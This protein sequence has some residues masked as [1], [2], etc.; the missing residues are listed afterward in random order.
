MTTDHEGFLWLERERARRA[1]LPP[2]PPIKH[3]V[4]YRVGATLDFYAAQ[5]LVE[6]NSYRWRAQDTEAL[7]TFDEARARLP[8]PFW[9]GHED[10]IR[11]YWWTWEK[12]FAN[13]R[14]PPARAFITNYIDTAFNGG[15]FLWDSIF[16][17]CFGRYGERV[18]PF[19]RTLDNFYALQYPDGFLPR[20]LRPDGTNQF[21][22]HDPAS[23]GPN[24][25]AWSEWGHYEMTGDRERLA[26]V[27]PV[28]LAYHRWL[29]LNRSWPDGSYFAC[30]LSGGADN[31]DRLPP[32]YEPHVHHGHLA[33]IDSSAQA[34]LS[35][36]LLLRMGEVLGRPDELADER[37]ELDLLRRWFNDRAWDDRLGMPTDVRRDG[38]PTGVKQVGCY[39]ALLAGLPSE[40][41][42]RRMA[43]HLEDP[44]SFAR[45]HRVP[46]L[47]A[48]Q[49]GYSEEGRYWNGSIWAPTNWM[50]LKA[51]ERYGFDDIAHNI[52][53]NHHDNVVRIW[54]ETGTVWENYAPDSLRPGKPAK[55]DF[56]GWTGLPP[57]AVL[58]EHRFGLRPKVP[59][60]TLV[61]DLRNLEAFGVKQYPFGA[62]DLDLACAARRTP[63]EK[64]VITVRSPAPLHIDLRWAGGREVISV[65]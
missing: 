65:P 42:A 15:L 38:R 17:L 36:D 14:R 10:A 44:A 60:N 51:L 25:V 33:W 21:H 31:M 35:A 34:A 22:P 3:A 6:E 23:T 26:C 13:L 59:E 30:G 64:P 49:A 32:G 52:A 19:R 4:A 9:E 41:Q 46:T 20:E 40:E 58:L 28:I 29:R 55:P 39:W 37:A 63:T 56:V 50:V 18:F 48:D 12:T 53:V 1:G 24:A 8:N 5:A 54:K 2:P 16:I 27:F 45:T 61:W 11:C 7:P 57:I 62:I 47:A 43:A